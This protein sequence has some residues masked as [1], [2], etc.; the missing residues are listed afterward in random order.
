MKVKEVKEK[1]M[2]IS[3]K[4]IHVGKFF[5]NDYMVREVVREKGDDIAY[6]AYLLDTGEPLHETSSGC[7]KRQITRWASRE[8]TSIEVRR[9]KTAEARE[10]ETQWGMRKVKEMLAKIPDEALIQEVKRRGLSV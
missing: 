2:A 4:D 9:M 7:S 1:D 8:A 6:Y 5:V 10:L 3:I